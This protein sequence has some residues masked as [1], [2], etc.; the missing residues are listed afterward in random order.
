MRNRPL[1]DI[2]ALRG[3][4]EAGREGGTEGGRG[5][6]SFVCR[7]MASCLLKKSFGRKDT[8]GG[9][10]TSSAFFSVAWLFYSCEALW[11]HSWANSVVSD[12]SDSWANSGHWHSWTAGYIYPYP[13]Q[14]S[15]NNMSKQ[16]EYWHTVK[17]IAVK[18]ICHYS[19]LEEIA[20]FISSRNT[21]KCQRLKVN[22]H[23]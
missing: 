21:K 13:K 9:H 8:K 19:K 12:Y 18:E 11:E 15:P 5:M 17:G 14:N 2:L 3:R 6:H 1:G 20:T 10:T 23:F 16:K 4:R 22:N 7:Q